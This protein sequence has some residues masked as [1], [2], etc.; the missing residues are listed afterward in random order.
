MK[1]RVLI[2]TALVLS[3]YLGVSNGYLTIFGSGMKQVLPYRVCMYP[4]ADRA[5][6]EKGIPF[7]S[8]QELSKLLEDYTA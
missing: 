6:L 7:S 8:S 1:P 4:Q 3:M 5:A 2:T